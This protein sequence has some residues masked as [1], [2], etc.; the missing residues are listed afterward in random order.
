MF[1]DGDQPTLEAVLDAREFRVST[2]EMLAQSHPHQTVISFKC[3]IPGP[4]KNN[5]IISA[6]FNQGFSSLTDAIKH[7]SMAVVFEKTVHLPTGS[8]GFLVID[9]SPLIVKGIAVLFEQQRLGRLYD[10]DVYSYV[11]GQLKSVSRVDLDLPVRH[12]LICDNDAKVCSSRRIHTVKQLQ[13]KIIEMCIREG[14]M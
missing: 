4:I 6:L 1:D 14:S 10:V 9:S 8:E 3:N 12:C 13:D 5:Q 7:Q 2:V 11:R